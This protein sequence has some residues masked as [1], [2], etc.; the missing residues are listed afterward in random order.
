MGA[1]MSFVNGA[2]NAGS[3]ILNKYITEDL[4]QQRAEALAALQ[5]RTAGEIR[6]DDAAFRD[7]RA[8]T[9]RK[10]REDDAISAAGVQDTIETK[11]LD[12]NSPVAQAKSAAAERDAVAARNRKKQDMTELTPIEAEREGTLTKARETAQTQAMADRLPLEVKKAAAMADAQA[13]A[14]AKYRERPPTVEQKMADTEKALGRPLTEPERMALIGLTKGG[15]ETDEVTIKD[16]IM[17]PDGSTREVTRK[18]KRRAGQGGNEED[19]VMAQARDAIA[20]GADPAKVNARLKEL[21]KAPIG[22]GDAAPAP[23]S[24]MATGKTR[25]DPISGSDLTEA[26]WD[27]KYGRGDF[28]KMP[29]DGR[30]S[31]KSF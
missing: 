31:L 8:P 27:R 5:R 10:M 9:E 15:S 7:Q 25:R 26:E 29:D 3:E 13:K 2:A 11:R 21:G 6:Q 23:K 19:P 30:P 28:R 24:L 14:S 4:A 16:T 17:S 1:L 18:E 22:G 20:K 12:P